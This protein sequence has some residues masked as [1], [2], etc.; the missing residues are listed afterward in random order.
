[1]GGEARGWEALT[2]IAVLLRWE[3]PPPC[4]SAVGNIWYGNGFP[5]V[6]QCMCLGRCLP[7]REMVAWEG[8]G[9][10]CT[11]G[12]PVSSICGCAGPLVNLCRAQSVGDISLVGELSATKKRNDGTFHLPDSCLLS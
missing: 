10:D 6:T 12:T 5:H 11:W 9:A 3:F 1:M 2:W 8:R 7:G 4:S